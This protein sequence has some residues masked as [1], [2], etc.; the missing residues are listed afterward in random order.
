MF[1]QVVNG[2]QAPAVEG[3]YADSNQVASVD[4]GAGAFV[5]GTAG[6]TVGRFA[7]ADPTWT[8]ANSY[9][10]GVPTGFVMRRQ[11]A[12]ITQYLAEASMSVPSGFGVTL[13]NQ[14]SFWV[15]NTG[16]NVV[17]PGMKA[18]ANSATGAVTFAATGTPPT[19]ASVT[20]SIAGNVGTGAIAATAGTVYISGT[21]LT[22]AT[23]TTGLFGVGQVLTGTGVATGTT[24]LSQL[25]GTAGGVGTYSVNI[26]QTVASAGSPVSVTTTGGALSVTVLTTGT[27]A[28]GQTLTGT[29]VPAGTTIVALGSGTGGTGTYVVNTNTTVASTTITASGGTLTVTAVGSGAIVLNDTITGANVTV[30][31]TAVTAFLTGTGGVGTYLVNNSQTAASATITVQAGVETKWIA[32]SAGAAG[33]LVKMS[34]FLLG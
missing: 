1:P 28:V 4:A 27:F 30:A 11:Q 25:S 14:G 19:S 21:T 24:I 17:T 16:A 3:D 31:G 20:G 8:Y 7:W 5:A 9:G 2:V 23:L 32:L 6:V 26:S 34:S 33:E 18:Y 22:V 15:R 13:H 10:V 12:L 29:S